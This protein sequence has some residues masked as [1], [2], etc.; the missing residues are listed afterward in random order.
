MFLQLQ[1]SQVD[2]LEDTIDFPPAYGLYRDTY[3]TTLSV[4]KGAFGFVK[5]AQRR[6]D[7]Q[8]VSIILVRYDLE[9]QSF[10]QFFFGIFCLP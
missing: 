5:L 1:S 4:G 6:V 2:E 8:E 10:L 9:P 3:K 7:R